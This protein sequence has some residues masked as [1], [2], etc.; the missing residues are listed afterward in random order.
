MI[1]SIL[2]QSLIVWPEKIKDK[3]TLKK[4]QVSA[5]LKIVDM[6]TKYSENH[7]DADLWKIRQGHEIFKRLRGSASLLEYQAIY[8]EVGMKEEIDEVIDSL[9]NIDKDIRHLAYKEKEMW[10]LDLKEDDDWRKLL[11]LI[12]NR[13]ETIAD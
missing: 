6:T 5:L 4:L 9:W 11:T 2:L 8:E 12:K 13:V 7:R 3:E 10:G 1:D